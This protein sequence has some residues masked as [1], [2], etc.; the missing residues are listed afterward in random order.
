LFTFAEPTTFQSLKIV[1]ED[2]FNFH[3]VPNLFLGQ[4][5]KKFEFIFLS[6]SSLDLIDKA[7]P[8]KDEV[9]TKIV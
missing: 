6:L 3:I 4:L 9:K 5:K 7:N 1:L 8:T 2:Y